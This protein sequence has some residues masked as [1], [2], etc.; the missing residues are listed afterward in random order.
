MPDLE[1]KISGWRQQMLAAGIESPVPLEELEIHLRDEIER[2]MK[3][4]LS[5]QKAFE[6]SVQQMG[7]AQLLRTEFKKAEKLSLNQIFGRIGALLLGIVLQ[8][9]GSFQFRDE[10]AMTNGKLVLWLL[11]LILQIWAV[12]SLWRTFCEFKKTERTIMKKIAIIGFGIFTILFGPALILPALDNTI[13]REFGITTSFGRLS[14][15]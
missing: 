4:G 8:F 15:E 9:P 5:E 6:I 13:N 14:L 1:E 11:G 3:S 7:Q 2:Q 10:F 12:I